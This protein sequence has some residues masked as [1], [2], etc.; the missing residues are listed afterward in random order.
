MEMS[1]LSWELFGPPEERCPGNHKGKQTQESRAGWPGFHTCETDHLW[2]QFPINSVLLNPFV[3][4][5]QNLT[6]PVRGPRV[7]VAAPAENTPKF[8]HGQ[9]RP[10]QLV[11]RRR[12]RDPSGRP[13]GVPQHRGNQSCRPEEGHSAAQRVPSP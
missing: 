6:S 9:R 7:R 5:L 11:A 4:L 8:R 12:S 2:I 10:W 1:L 13:A 3:K